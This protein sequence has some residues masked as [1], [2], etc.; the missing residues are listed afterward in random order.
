MLPSLRLDQHGHECTF[1]LD[2]CVKSEKIDVEQLKV[3][4]LNFSVEYNIKQCL[5]GCTFFDT[6]S[7]TLC[8][9]WR[10]IF[11]QLVLE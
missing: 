8:T 7:V 6:L 3:T 5:Q 2:S 10:L 9:T 11:F 4:E 1:N